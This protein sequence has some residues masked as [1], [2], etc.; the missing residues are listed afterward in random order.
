VLS[1]F[2]T[3]AFFFQQIVFAAPGVF[4]PGRVPPAVLEDRALR[5][6]F[7]VPESVAVIEDVYQAPDAVRDAGQ[8]VYLLQ[9][10]HTNESGQANLARA[11]DI[12]IRNEDVRFVFSEAGEGDHSLFFLKELSEPKLR[13]RVAM[14]Y[15]RKGLLHGSEYLNLTGER[16]F[17]LWGVEDRDLYWDSVETYRGIAGGREKVSGY[18]SRIES[19]MQ[20]LKGEIYSEALRAFDGIYRG[21]L[22]DEIPMTGYF[23]ALREAA[24]GLGVALERYRHLSLLEHLRRMEARIDFEKAGLEQQRLV[25]SLS[26]EKRA[27]VLE[28]AKTQERSPFKV[29]GHD[30]A[31]GRAFYALL[32]ECLAGKTKGYPELAKYF[33]Y[34]KESRKLNAGSV[35]EELDALEE[36]VFERMARTQDERLMV[37]FSRG[38]EL[39][40]KLFELKVGP[41]EY[42]KVRAGGEEFNISAMTGF[43]NKKIMDLGRHYE[44]ALFRD[45]DYGGL[46]EE[47]LSFYDLTR[48]RD[49]VFIERMLAKMEAEGQKKA[50]LVT[51]GYHAPN[52][53]ALLK[54]RGISYASLIPQVLHETD[55]GRYERILLSQTDDGSGGV[56]ALAA[57]GRTGDARD[58][59]MTELLRDLDVRNEPVFPRLL[60]A[61]GVSQREAEAHL[62]LSGARLAGDELPREGSHDWALPRITANV[63]VAS[64][65]STLFEVARIQ[66]GIQISVR[67]EEEI[68]SLLAAYYV[69]YQKN[70]ADWSDSF[71][72]YLASV[73]AHAKNAERLVYTVAYAVFLSAAGVDP[74]A[75][76][77]LGWMGDLLHGLEQQGLDSK[78]YF[79]RLISKYPKAFM[80]TPQITLGDVER[81]C[82]L[83]QEIK[84]AGQDPLAIFAKICGAATDF[85]L[86]L[87]LYFE[88]FWESVQGWGA[89]T[90]KSEIIWEEVQWRRIIEALRECDLADGSPSAFVY[91]QGD[92]YPEATPWGGPN[93]RVYPV[94]LP[95]RIEK[96]ARLASQRLS[97][98]RR[99]FS[100]MLTRLK[101]KGPLYKGDEFVDWED[102][103]DEL[104]ERVLE[105]AKQIQKIIAPVNRMSVEDIISKMT[106]SNLL[107]KYRI[108]E[109]RNGLQKNLPVTYI[110]NDEL[111]PS[112]ESQDRPRFIAITVDGKV[113]EKMQAQIAGK[114]GKALLAES[115]DLG[116][117]QHYKNAWWDVW[118]DGGKNV[119]VDDGTNFVAV[120]S[121]FSD[122]THDGDVKA[123]GGNRYYGP[124]QL[125]IEMS[126]EGKKAL[127][128]KKER[129]VK[130]WTASSISAG[131]LL[132]FYITG[133]DMYMD[134]AMSWIIQQ[135]FKVQSDLDMFE[136][137]VLAS[138]SQPVAQ[139]GFNH[140]E[141]TATSIAVVESLMAVLDNPKLC[142]ELNIPETVTIAIQG[143]GDVGG[144]I[145][146]YLYANY[147]DL[148]M[149]GAGRKIK[150]VAVSD[151]KG[152]IKNMDGLD[153]VHLLD[154]IDVR[155]KM[156]NEHKA[157][158]T[159]PEFSLKEMY[160]KGVEGRQ[161][162]FETLENS[163]D[164]LWLGAT[165]DIPAAQPNVITKKSQIRKLKSL[166]TRVWAE[167]GNITFKPGLE[168]EF[169]LP[170]GK[171]KNRVLLLSAFLANGG[172]VQAS[173]EQLYHYHL[174]GHA[175]DDYL[176]DRDDNIHNRRVHVQNQIADLAQANMT[177]L[178]KAYLDAKGETSLF[179]ISQK[180]IREMREK[181]KRILDGEMTRDEGLD[182]KRRQRVDNEQ[183]RIPRMYSR[184]IAASEMARESVV[185]KS[186]T[187][188]DLEEVLN[189]KA[190][191]LGDLRHAIFVIGRKRTRKASILEKLRD[192]VSG[193]ILEKLDADDSR[194]DYFDPGS[195]NSVPV[196]RAAAEALGF[197]GDGDALKVLRE[198]FEDKAASVR[199]AAEWAEELIKDIQ[200]WE[201]INLAAARLAEEHHQSFGAEQI[202]ATLRSA[203]IETVLRGIMWNRSPEDELNQFRMLSGRE[204][205]LR[206]ETKFLRRGDEKENEGLAVL[207]VPQH[208]GSKEHHVYS[209]ADKTM[210]FIG[211]IQE[212]AE[213]EYVFEIRLMDDGHKLPH[214]RRLVVTDGKQ[215][216][217]WLYSADRRLKTVGF[218]LFGGP[219]KI[220]P[221]DEV[222]F[223]QRT[224][225]STEIVKSRV[226][227]T[228]KERVT[229]LLEHGK[230][231]AFDGT[232]LAAEDIELYADRLSRRLW[233]P[234]PED[235]DPR[236][237]EKTTV[238]AGAALDGSHAL[239]GAEGYYTK[240]GWE[241]FS[242]G[243]DSIV[244]F[245]SRETRPNPV[246]LIAKAGVGGQ[247]TPHQAL[248]EM[249][250]LVDPEAGKVLGIYELGED[251]ESIIQKILDENGW[252]WD[253]VVID[254]SSKS[255][256]T[257]ETMLNGSQLLQIML[258][259]MA[260]ADG[261]DGE[262]FAKVF[263]ETLHEVNFIDGKERPAGDLFKVDEERF[264]TT[265]LVE[266]LSRPRGLI[267]VTGP[268]GSGK[269]SSLATM[270]NYINENFSRHIITVEDPIEIMH[271]HKKGIVTQREL[272]SDVPSF[273]EAVVKALRQDPDVILIGEMRD[274]STMESAIRAAETGHLVF[275]TL[276]TTGAARTVDRII[277]VFPSGQQEQIRVQ[278]AG[279]LIAVVSQAL[280]P[281]IDQGGRIAALEIMIATPAIRNLIREG[282]TYQVTSEMQTGARFGM[283]ALDDHLKE[284]YQKGII[285]YDDMLEVAQDPKEL[286]EHAAKAMSGDGKKK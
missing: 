187:L 259:Q 271:P 126:M 236:I 14:S 164:V 180:M 108:F 62:A 51:G 224:F 96:G 190:A 132:G 93:E 152:G 248:S 258:K 104:F 128:Q 252:S 216:R 87:M 158:P 32:E 57:G 71:G 184:L 226:F 278:L 1:V 277:D 44:L 265:S 69:N 268:T 222:Q 233:E 185:D 165:V 92:P 200:K 243:V 284:M 78:V 103:Y 261:L 76:D 82:A 133:P 239:E 264:G 24:A 127:P 211:F 34:L 94:Y 272:E 263:F 207:T 148:L 4:S 214:K 49:E 23:E 56:A 186:E 22:A 201:S 237:V 102:S 154:L 229:R 140:I 28:A 39:L 47:C 19:A 18:L 191:T 45:K 241:I 161:T 179:D 256:S 167:G 65:A 197:I 162:L 17:V 134:E 29:N 114:N 220:D 221:S 137:P 215:G 122:L 168:K 181:K 280:L 99:A 205:S 98:E 234:L 26:E 177:A 189:D 225:T 115:L 72:G 80:A 10:A 6:P 279:T 246:K 270:L 144:G 202:A 2:L 155:E 113:T 169:H 33:T 231:S 166:G 85:N 143:F 188:K 89:V 55:Y 21:Y 250:E 20:V 203:G 275:S 79:G 178:I 170:Y 232:R 145:L 7:E 196:R 117:T 105:D 228:K 153:I 107:S 194:R 16:N 123:K 149:S 9:D 247:H 238:P 129:M 74:A 157:D 135:A 212:P 141:W 183:R 8:T 120:T 31:T 91:N 63:M 260:R 27:A 109:K 257:L 13:K 46:L 88:E 198:A 59:L 52:L 235:V 192:I 48:K 70:M 83:T 254:I 11:L 35:L 151:S 111:V 274:I 58:G 282:K 75:N 12:V 199:V 245:L 209:V 244:D 176:I 253:Q 171:K 118:L 217:L 286:S 101:K 210:T 213:S 66:G 25:E 267:L 249:F 68:R 15:L 125:G 43:L 119:I 147:G 173:K 266:L 262:A 285:S 50:V 131:A 112:Y 3:Q 84:K 90:P 41:E 30:E 42:R 136:V 73:F 61:L 146:K 38:L 159:K 37:R 240:W 124:R 281:R 60:A 53:K 150:I 36:L 5:L 283:R 219:L 242:D 223:A 86:D 175:I 156:V 218:G 67:Q 138:T 142:E 204:G 110:F 100:H 208:D 195:K 227:F 139:G 81:F 64:Q 172:G 106:Y 77:S 269:T 116:R 182:F 276:H 95:A 230:K 54:G 121:V 273:A 160:K 255:G 251:L 193:K 40:K 206:A 163:E 130:K 174:D 97:K